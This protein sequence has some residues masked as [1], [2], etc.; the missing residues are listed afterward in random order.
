[1]GH[2]RNLGR[3]W[4]KDI[5]IIIYHH[6][7]NMVHYTFVPWTYTDIHTPIVMKLL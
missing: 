6:N 1:M 5:F 7:L 3:F 2:T 4:T